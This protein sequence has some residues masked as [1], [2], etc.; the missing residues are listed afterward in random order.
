M[1]IPLEDTVADIVGK[2]QRGLGISDAQ[3]AERIGVPLGELDA[4]KQ[5]RGAPVA[6]VDKLAKTLELGPKALTAIA[7][8]TYTPT[9]TLPKTGF[10][11]ANTTYGDMTV[12]AY[13]VWDPATRLAAAFDTGG[14]CSPLVDEIKKHDLTLQDVYLT[15]THIDHVT[16]L[17]RLLEKVGGS[18]GVHAPEAEPLEGASTFKPGVTFSLGKL[19]IEA[20]ET[21]GHSPGGT[22][23]HVHGLD[24]PLAIVGDA[25]FAGSAGGIR[26]DYHTAL[27]LI[28]DNILSAQDNTI[29]APGHGPLT[30]VKQE[31]ERN[32]FFPEFRQAVATDI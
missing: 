13:L 31:K 29:L 17:D 1:A 27:K 24:A 22:T 8:G 2:A 7:E 5:V 26:T 14:D 19:H 28:R 25:L 11:Q 20:R 4:V 18:V 10:Y 9:V 21:S 16:D 32:P 30:T 6:L 3:L 23:Y 15:H 12:N